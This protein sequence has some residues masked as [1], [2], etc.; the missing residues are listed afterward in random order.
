MSKL[1]MIPV[2]VWSPPHAG[3]WAIRS[4]R[5]TGEVYISKWTDLANANCREGCTYDVVPFPGATP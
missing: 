2:P 3:P 5:P 1:H 4:T